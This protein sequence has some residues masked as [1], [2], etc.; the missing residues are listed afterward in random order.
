[1]ITFYF[2]GQ[3]DNYK[4]FTNG[5]FER[6]IHISLNKLPKE[7]RDIENAGIFKLLGM[8]VAYEGQEIQRYEDR[9]Y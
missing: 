5:L 1:M 6:E 3:N 9:S 7:I 2:A 4:P 8:V